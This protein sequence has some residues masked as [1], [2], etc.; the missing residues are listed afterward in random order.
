VDH[1]T[2][3]Q[4]LLLRPILDSPDA[5]PEYSEAAKLIKRG[6]MYP[7]VFEVEDSVLYRSP[8]ELQISLVLPRTFRSAYGAGVLGFAMVGKTGDP[9][10]ALAAYEGAV[11]L[12]NGNVIEAVASILAI[13]QDL[14]MK[15]YLAG[16]RHRIPACVIA[17]YLARQ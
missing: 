9:D 14:V 16:V 1:V 3:E 13:S 8:R 17:E 10:A 5:L 11:V 6:L 2:P 15:L 4:L 12:R 7:H